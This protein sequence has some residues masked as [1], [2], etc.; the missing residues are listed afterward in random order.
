VV[1][2]GK[3]L[4]GG[5]TDLALRCAVHTLAPHIGKGAESVE[6][7]EGEGG[8][9]KGIAIAT[10]CHHRCDDLS[11]VA[12]A[13]VRRVFA[14]RGAAVGAAEA[15]ESAGAREAT[16]W[17]PKFDLIRLVTSWACC[18]CPCT[19]KPPKP[20]G[21]AQAS[22]AAA[23]PGWTCARGEGERDDVG[24]E[25]EQDCQYLTADE[26]Q[27]L[28]RECK[29]ILDFGRVV[30]LRCVSLSI[31]KGVVLCAV[32]CLRLPCGLVRGGRQRTA[33][34]GL[35]WRPLIPRIRRSASDTDSA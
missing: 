7:V 5:A 24:K 21:K 18:A 26:R 12:S 19:R 17:V 6:E 3:H 10:C 15:G 16:A 29:R 23:A 27:R 32:A 22:A 13:W 34:V 14:T 20:Q 31:L 30:W 2:T 9:L 4:C 25:K 11:Y 1:I 35:R 28:G 33:A 8:V